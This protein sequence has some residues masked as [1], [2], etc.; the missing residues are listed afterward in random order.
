MSRRMRWVGYV[1]CMGKM[2]NAY[3]ILVG[4]PEG[5]RPCERLRCR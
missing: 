4:K 5:T 2:V 1:A 3:E